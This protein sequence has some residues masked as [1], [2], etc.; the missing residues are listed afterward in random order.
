MSNDD[1]Q[2]RFLQKLLIT[3]VIIKDDII[4]EVFDGRPTFNV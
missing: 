4:S 1:Q 3:G 2:R